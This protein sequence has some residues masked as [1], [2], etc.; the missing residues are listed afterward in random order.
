MGC[1]PGEEGQTARNWYDSVVPPGSYLVLSHP[2]R[3]VAA[4]PSERAAQRSDEHVAAPMRRRSR[5][6]AG[7][8]F[9]GLELFEPDVRHRRG[10]KPA[11]MRNNWCGV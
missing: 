3:D 7:R 9:D 6:G 10:R 5:A 2:A 1:A 11:V 8:F 4:E